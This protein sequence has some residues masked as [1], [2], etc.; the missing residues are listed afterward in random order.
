MG[1][2]S[3]HFA[4]GGSSSRIPGAKRKK[5]MGLCLYYEGGGLDV[6]SIP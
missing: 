2:Q 1:D 5:R 3:L 6:D 4:A